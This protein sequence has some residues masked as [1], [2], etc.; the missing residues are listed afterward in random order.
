MQKMRLGRTELMIGRSGFGALPI[1][2]I[3]IKQAGKLLRRA[4]DNGFTFFDTARGYSDSEQ[5]IGAGL[6]DVRENII[7]ATKSSAKDR[8]T[9]E[10]HVR[11][12]LL[13]LKTRYIDLLQLHNPPEVP[14]ASDPNGVYA[15]LLELKEQ[16]IIR[17]IGITNHRLET[18]EKAIQSDLF[19]T[20]QFPL[21][22]LSSE[23]EI[24]LIEECRKRDMGVV[25]M[26]ALAGGLITNVGATFAFLRR[27]DNLVPIWGIQRDSELE[28]FIALENNPPPLDDAMQDVIDR[29]R[30]ELAGNFCRGCGYCLPCPSDIQIS[31]AARASLLI[32]RAPQENFLTDAWKQKMDQI[33]ECTECGQCRERCPYGLDT[34]NLLKK[35]LKDYLEFYSRHAG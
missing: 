25:A 4:Y 2:R 34:P 27:F 11:E 5:K 1:Q 13:N 7:I 30:S 32:R 16:G 31:S 8:Q 12:S 15:T 33:L 24:N 3:G 6:S 21:S 26:K 28:E 10:Q 17:H 35:N 29:D 18:A 19:D 14:D 22:C 23:K 9:L 20:L